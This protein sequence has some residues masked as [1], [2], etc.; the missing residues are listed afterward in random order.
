M[1]K[2]PDHLYSKEDRRTNRIC[3]GLAVFGLIFI[4]AGLAFDNNTL[5]ILGGI[6]AGVSAVLTR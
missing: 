6:Y 5:V 2:L 4:A 3:G 1:L